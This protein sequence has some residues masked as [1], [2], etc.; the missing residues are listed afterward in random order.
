MPLDYLPPST[1]ALSSVWVMQGQEDRTNDG[2]Q[3]TRELCKCR[4]KVI[5]VKSWVSISLFM[6]FIHFLILFFL[7]LLSRHLTP[8]Y[9]PLAL[10][11]CSSI[12][13]LPSKVLQ[14]HR[15]PFGLS[16]L[17]NSWFETTA[18]HPDDSMIWLFGAW[19]S[20]LLSFFSSRLA[21]IPPDDWHWS[22]LESFS[23]RTPI[24]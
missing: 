5:L 17:T 23:S 13:R 20:F 15:G 24:P 9:S 18:A 3:V 19:S 22:I 1:R 11:R 8:L 7:F 16:T 6:S 2:P 4:G 14:G 10:L 12:F 21:F